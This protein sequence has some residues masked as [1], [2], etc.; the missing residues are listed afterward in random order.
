[1]KNKQLK[2]Y[3][4]HATFSQ[5]PQEI[6]VNYEDVNSIIHRLRMVKSEEEIKILQ[7]SAY[8]A[9][10]AH[11]SVMRHAHT[12]QYENE[13]E[14]VWQQ[15]ILSQGK[16]HWP[17]PPIIAAGNR[18]TIL[19]Y[20]DNNQKIE[21]GDWLLID[22]GAEYH[23]YA[24]DITRTYPI[25]NTIA[26]QYVEL[27][28]MV[29]KCQQKLIEVARPGMQITDL[30]IMAKEMLTTGC[31]LLGIITKDEDIDMYYPHGIG[32]LI[33]L[34][35]HDVT[36]EKHFT[37]QENMTLTIEPGIYINKNLD[38]RDYWSG[39]GVRIEDNIIIG[40]QKNENYTKQIP[41]NLSD[42]INLRS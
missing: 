13:I 39:F 5:L 26:P 36:N 11:V 32:H 12:L 24:S 16:S 15:A 25:T 34:D 3:S 9:A 33:G 20:N 22:S 21:N 2:F 37:L 8:Q 23:G 10:N 42:I 41:K 29:L 14:G 38:N 19:H 4:N 30:Q 31:K 17:Y 1:M 40:K 18:S 35:T 28:E 27:Y 6:D 7:Y